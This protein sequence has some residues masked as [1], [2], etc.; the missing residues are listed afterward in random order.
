[1]DD[2]ALAVRKGLNV[3]DVLHQ[4]RLSLRER[5]GRF[6]AQ[7]DGA[8][9]LVLHTG[10]RRDDYIGAAVA[11]DLTQAL[12]MRLLFYY[13]RIKLMTAM[14]TLEIDAAPEVRATI[15]PEVIFFPCF[16][17]GTTISQPGSMALELRLLIF[18]TAPFIY[19]A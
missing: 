12:V 14:M 7:A 19:M 11:E 6:D 18:S 3:T 10:N 17:V 2:G 4:D 5:G 13:L 8:D 15:S 1:M 9:M 16:L